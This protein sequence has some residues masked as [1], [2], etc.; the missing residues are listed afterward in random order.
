MKKRKVKSLA[1]ATA[2]ISCISSLSFNVSALDER[3]PNTSSIGVESVMLMCEEFKEN[4][5]YLND[6][7][8]ENKTIEKSYIYGAE[9]LQVVIKKKYS[10]INKVWTAKDFGID[11]S[12][13]IADVTYM[14]SDYQKEYEYYPEFIE[15]LHSDNFSQHLGINVSNLT[16]AELIKLVKSFEKSEFVLATS[17]LFCANTDAQNLKCGDMNID[18]KVDL[19]DLT[20]LSLSLI[21]DKDLSFI[22]DNVSDT[23]KDGNTNLADL[24]RLKQ[25]ISLDITSF[26]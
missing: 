2:I 5:K 6:E 3:V 10:E 17:I 1:L 11:D 22:P 26:D 14:S 7:L 8:I 21:G 23:T 4:E 19:T 25:Y 24:A 20:E 18:G 13:Q 12:I 9:G 15:Y 16:N